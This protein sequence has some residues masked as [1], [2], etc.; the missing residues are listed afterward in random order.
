MVCEGASEQFPDHK[1]STIPTFPE[2]LNS[3]IWH[4]IF[5]LNDMC[6]KQIEYQMKSILVYIPHTNI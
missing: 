4:Y 5:F 2:I 1:N 6:N 3:W